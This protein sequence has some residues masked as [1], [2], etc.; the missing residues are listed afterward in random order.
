M[1]SLKKNCDLNEILDAD[2]QL[3]IEQ[4]GKLG[5]LALFASF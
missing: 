2:A 3:P 4:V 5:N 1:N